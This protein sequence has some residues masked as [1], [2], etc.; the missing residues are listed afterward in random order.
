MQPPSDRGKRGH[1]AVAISVVEED[2]AYVLFF[3]DLHLSGS[4]GRRMWEHKKFVTTAVVPK[5]KLQTMN[6]SAD[7]MAAMGL[8]I[9]G[10]LKAMYATNKS[11]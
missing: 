11:R 4:S 2:D 6:F 9:L 3:D 5:E 1:L 7:E 10:S 8:T